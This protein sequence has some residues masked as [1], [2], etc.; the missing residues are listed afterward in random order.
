MKILVAEDSKADRIL[1]ERILARAGYDVVSADSS[2]TALEVYRAGGID[3]AL[4]DWMLPSTGGLTLIKDIR[5][6]DLNA[7][8]YCIAIIVTAKARKEDAIRALESGADD[9]ISKP[10]DEALLLTKL[11]AIWRLAEG[12]R[13]SKEVV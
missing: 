3:I 6:V 1:L 4:L 12:I 5:E 7:Q 10:V 9:F 8:R 11:K 2:D 13:Q